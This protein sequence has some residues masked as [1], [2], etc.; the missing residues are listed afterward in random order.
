MG[1]CYYISP[2]NTEELSGYIT[3][4]AFITCTLCKNTLSSVGGPSNDYIC[5]ECGNKIKTG[6]YRLEFDDD[7]D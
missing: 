2:L 4:Q 5:T 7:H 3:T 6:K 1:Y